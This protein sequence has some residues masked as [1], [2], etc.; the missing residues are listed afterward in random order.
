VAEYTG[1]K[2]VTRKGIGQPKRSEFTDPADLEYYDRIIARHRK[3]MGIPDSTP[4][5]EVNVGQHYGALMVNPEW[6]WHMHQL[7]GLARTA[8]TEPDTYSHADREWVDQVLGADAKA[9]HVFPLHIDDAISVGVRLEAI[10]AI[11]SGHEENLT[12]D[13]ALL[14]RYIRQVLSG[15]VDDATWE[16]MFDRLGQKGIVEYTTFILLF[17]LILRSFQ[18]F[19]VPA[20]SDEEIDRHIQELKDG[21]VVPNSDWQRRFT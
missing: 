4:D 5:D 3:I 21:T 11:R 7:G 18:A 1:V 16:K 19:G 13:E 2:A 14:T 6:A 10:D 15:T 20:P 9:N 8:G 17:N 12:E